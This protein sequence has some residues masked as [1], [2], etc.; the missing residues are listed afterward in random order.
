[1]GSLENSPSTVVV[2]VAGRI[3]AQGLVHSRHSVNTCL[4]NGG[5]SLIFRNNFESWVPVQAG[6]LIVVGFQ[7]GSFHSSFENA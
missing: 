3:V 7:S 1:M 6:L 5:I 2:A 4:R